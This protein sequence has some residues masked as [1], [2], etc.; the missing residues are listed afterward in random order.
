M[1]SLTILT[2]HQ[3]FWGDE[4][5]ENDIGEKGGTQAREE[6]CIEDCDRKS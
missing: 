6:K 3:I 2:P 1:R 4:L 5:K